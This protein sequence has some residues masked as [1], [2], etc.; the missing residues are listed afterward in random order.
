M[1]RRQGVVF[2]VLT[3]LLASPLW[4]Q[5]ADPLTAQQLTAMK[6]D[7][8]FAGEPNGSTSCDLL[9][10]S[11]YVACYSETRKDPLWAAYRVEWPESHQ[12]QPRPSRFKIDERT[13]A[14][15]SHDDYTQPNYTRASS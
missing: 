15:V 3:L 6:G 4:A 13:T 1:I 11:G 12:V 14:R 9:E 2:C 7:H 8:L 10:N 5:A